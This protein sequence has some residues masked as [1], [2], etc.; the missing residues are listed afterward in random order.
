MSKL[1]SSDLAALSDKDRQKLRKAALIKMF[2]ALF[3]IIA[4]IVFGSI[5]SHTF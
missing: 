4:V 2:I 1:N 5:D 3:L